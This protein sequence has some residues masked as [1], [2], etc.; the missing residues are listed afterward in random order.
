MKILHV[1]PSM[2]MGGAET[3]AINLASA[4]RS[5]GHDTGVCCVMSPPEAG[6]LFQKAREN[7]LS[8]Y[9]AFS[10]HEPHVLSSIHMS[11]LFRKIGPDVI[12]SHL[13]RANSCAALSARLAGIK[14]VIGTFHNSVIWKNKTQQKWGRRT[15]HIQDGLFCDSEL[16]RR[17][18]LEKCASASEK[19]RVLYPGVPP[20]PPRAERTEIEEFR[21]KWGV[22]EDDRVIGIISRL[23]EVKDHFTFID[24]AD[25]MLKRKP[26]LKFLIAG[27]GPLKDKIVDY[28]REKNRSRD[29]HVLGFVPKLDVVW[30]LLDVFVLTS[31][32]EGFPVSVLEAFNAGIPVV[33]TRVGGIPEMITSGKEGYLAE[34]G[35]PESVAEQTL[36]ILS[37]EEIRRSMKQN[38]RNTAKRFHIDR[39]AETSI[40]F[41]RELSR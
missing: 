22:S 41:Y 9:Y 21:K 38:C 36:H 23:A 15:A 11:R 3:L 25:R 10:K 32:S 27:S 39:I 6:A 7:G 16:M 14:C 1:I 18:L 4:Q 40:K 34:P 13:P 30:S 37:N 28:I 20:A 5:L 17:N 2:E 35:D 31:R 29:I 26:R 24:A 12:Q 8:M 19:T 33:A